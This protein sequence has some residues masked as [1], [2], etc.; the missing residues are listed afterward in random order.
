MNLYKQIKDKLLEGWF[1]QEVQYK[2]CYQ[3]EVSK[4]TGDTTKDIFCIIGKSTVN[5]LMADIKFVL[6]KAVKETIPLNFTPHQI[7]RGHAITF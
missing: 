4:K 1:I 5:I 7:T 3:Y 2:N 6:K